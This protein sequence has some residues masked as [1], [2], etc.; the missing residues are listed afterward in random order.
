MKTLLICHEDAP[1]DR[2][3][4]ARW[5]ASYSDF[6]GMIVL[7]EGKGKL[8]QR[9]K[10]EIKRVGFLRFIDVVAFRFYYKFFLASRDALEEQRLL[11]SLR[12][13]YAALPADLPTLYTPS[14]NSDEAEQFLT[15]LMPDLVVARC[16]V[17]LK[18]RIF[19]IPSLGTWVMHP[20]ICPQYRNAHGCF[21]ALAQNDREN[22]GMTLLKVDAGVDTG[23]IYAY[24]RCKVD[25]LHDSHITIQARAVFDNLDLLRDKLREVGEGKARPIEIKASTSA[26]WGQPWLSAYWRWKK[27]ARNR[28]TS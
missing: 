20:G 25:E 9:A 26:V 1:L 2:E 28:R 8:V 19:T 6:V 4:L 21:W 12:D 22:V 5:L 24:G 17:L 14:P 10:R 18:K 23:P 13:K 15:K 3:G 27:R 16:K 7:R 11:K